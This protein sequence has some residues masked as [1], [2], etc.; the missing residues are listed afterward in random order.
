MISPN[1]Y[2]C[3]KSCVSNVCD[4]MIRIVIAPPFELSCAYHCY[5]E[6]DFGSVCNNRHKIELFVVEYWNDTHYCYCKSDFGSL[7]N[8]RHKNITIF[9]RVLKWYTLLLPTFYTVICSSDFL[10][11]SFIFKHNWC[12][13]IYGLYIYVLW[14]EME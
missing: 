2:K 7:Y 4:V 8:K 5:C 14:S 12:E 9:C 3:T 1:S 10:L 11:S 6:S 13:N